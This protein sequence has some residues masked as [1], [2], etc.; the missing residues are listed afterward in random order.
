MNNDTPLLSV[1]IPVYNEKDTILELLDR[2]KKVDI[3]KE[4]LVIEDSSTDGTRDLLRDYQDEQV[5]ILFSEHNGG[6]GHAVRWGWREARGKV[7]IHQDADL[8]Y[9]PSEYNHLVQPILDGEADVV[10]G[11]RFLGQIEGM[12]FLSNLGNRVLVIVTNLLYRAR[13]TDLMTCY[14]CFRRELLPELGCQEN[15][16]ELEPEVTARVLRRKL[17]LKEVPIRFRGRDYAEG[18][19]MK[20]K[21]FFTVLWTLLRNRFGRA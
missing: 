3:P 21:H 19:K 2:V 15:G 17:K 5:R 14:K 13:I 4:I 7:V 9:D 1:I 6:R 16:F 8:E 11:S 10:Y 20:A 12:L 18:K